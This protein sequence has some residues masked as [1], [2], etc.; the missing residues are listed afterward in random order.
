MFVCTAWAKPDSDVYHA[1]DCTGGDG[2]CGR[3]THAYDLMRHRSLDPPKRVDLEAA[4]AWPPKAIATAKKLDEDLEALKKEA[5][6]WVRLDPNDFDAQL[7]LKLYEGLKKYP[8]F[9]DGTAAGGILQHQIDA[10]ST[11]T[12][13]KL[14]EDLDAT[15]FTTTT[16]LMMKNDFSLIDDGLLMMVWCVNLNGKLYN[17]E[18]NTPNQAFQ[19]DE[20]EKLMHMKKGKP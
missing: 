8:E 9:L 17:I 14:D 20:T 6:T 19:N 1:V 10:L 11:G 7:V 4:E 15:T 5:E 18:S 2:V 12:T 16:T 3:C 13:R